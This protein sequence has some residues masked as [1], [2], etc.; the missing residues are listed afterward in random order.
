[1]NERSIAE[2]GDEFKAQVRERF[3]FL[4]KEF[5]F[6]AAL[7]E[8]SEYAHRL[9][10][11]NLKRNKLVEV[12]NA[13]HGVDYGFEVNIHLA[14]GRRLLDQRN[15]VYYRLKEQQ[16]SEFEYLEGAAEKL[17]IV[18]SNEA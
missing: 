5:D 2:R 9:T 17:R 15:M 10:F 16:D 1:M 8:S 14:L 4:V 13:F 12:V 6:E 18:L 3:A 7:D 11:R